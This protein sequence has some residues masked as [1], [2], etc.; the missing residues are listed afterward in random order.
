MKI[1][2]DQNGEIYS[3]LLTLEKWK[4][5]SE[6]YCYKINYVESCNAW[7]AQDTNRNI[8]GTYCI[9]P[10]VLAFRAWISKPHK[11]S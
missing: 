4:E 1:Q 10:G 3:N 11:T 2:F 7:F 6:I 8:K 9:Q 5:I